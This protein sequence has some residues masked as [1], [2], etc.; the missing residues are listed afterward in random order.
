MPLA[1]KALDAAVKAEQREV[2]HSFA[3]KVLRLVR[4]QKKITK[5]TLLQAMNLFR[6]V[7]AWDESMTATG[8]HGAYRKSPTAVFAP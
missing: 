4:Q 1:L 6:E 8:R 5:S 3:P 7:G 2:G